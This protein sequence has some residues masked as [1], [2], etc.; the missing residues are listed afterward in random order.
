MEIIE[1]EHIISIELSD[2][3]GEFVFS[4]IMPTNDL[5]QIQIERSCNV[6]TK[7]LI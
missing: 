5:N 3:N 1:L 4:V 7:M 2:E 6:I